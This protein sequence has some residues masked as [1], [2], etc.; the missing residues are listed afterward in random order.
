LC[1]D[2]EKL[3]S[4]FASAKAIET[5]DTNKLLEK[6]MRKLDRIERDVVRIKKHIKLDD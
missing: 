2:C 6:I 3:L 4:K 1:K 5:Y